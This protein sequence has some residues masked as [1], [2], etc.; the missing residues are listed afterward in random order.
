LK[1]EQ[2]QHQV[3]LWAATNLFR[4]EHYQNPD[5]SWECKSVT[6]Y[7]FTLTKTMCGSTPSRMSSQ[8][9]RLTEYTLS[10]EY[11]STYCFHESFPVTA[12]LMKTM[13]HQVCMS[14][15]MTG[16]CGISWEFTFRNGFCES[17]IFCESSL[18]GMDFVRVWYFV[19]VNLQE[20]IS[21]E[22]GISWEFAFTNGF[23][24]SSLSRK[25]VISWEY[26]PPWK[27][28]IRSISIQIQLHTW[29]KYNIYRQLIPIS[30]YSNFNQIIQPLQ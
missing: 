22:F 20:W 25:Q 24:G 21:W 2:E 7:G 6:K 15:F 8:D 23:R 30:M 27:L 19:R 4:K 5:I 29:S 17:L 16:F 11:T 12:T 18:T 9:I 26:N 10:W 28:P 14:I 1:H 13:C 3:S